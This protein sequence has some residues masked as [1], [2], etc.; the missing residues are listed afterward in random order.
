M[1]ITPVG[2]AADLACPTGA[3]GIVL[4]AHGSGSSRLSPRNRH[5]ASALQEGGLATLLFDLLTE[6]EALDR[7][8]VFDIPLLADRLLAA[9]RWLREQAGAERTDP[10]VPDLRGLSIGYFGSSTGAA[11]ALVA[12]ARPDNPV[13]AVVSRGGRPDLAATALPEVRAPTLLIVGGAD[14]PVLALNQAALEALGC[15]KRLAVVPGAT[16]LFEETGALDE[17]IDLA[18]GW[19]LR[20][21]AP[22]AG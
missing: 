2:L 11:A 12:A 14:T 15:V 7:R 16:H 21:L 3:R 1:L 9:T 20:H 10:E 13:A 5:V 8:L 6:E 19:F 22:P 4:F 17:V 18:R